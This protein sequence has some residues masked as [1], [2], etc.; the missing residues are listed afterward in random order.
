MPS[1]CKHCGKLQSEAK[2]ACGEADDGKH[3][4]V[5]EDADGKA[6]ADDKADDVKE[7]C[8]HCGKTKAESKLACGESDDGKH[9]FVKLEVVP[10][11][12]AEKHPHPCKK[13]PDAWMY[14]DG[15]RRHM[16]L[17]KAAG[18][19][20]TCRNAECDDHEGYAK[21]LA[22]VEAP[23]ADETSSQGAPSSKRKRPS[24]KST[25]QTIRVLKR[26]IVDKEK[27]V[28]ELQHEIEELQACVQGLEE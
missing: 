19:S 28:A 25:Y 18:V 23:E 17:K 5:A 6:D 8:K 1:K 4:F 10:E 2:L 13:C 12:V 3:L 26:Y 20:K 7:L 22:A 9:E 21:A 15:S 24:S 27:A 11:D 14:P 16:R